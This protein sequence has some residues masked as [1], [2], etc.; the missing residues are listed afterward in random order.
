MFRGISLLL[1]ATFPSLNSSSVRA[2]LF[3]S[4]TAEELSADHCQVLSNLRCE[5]FQQL[6]GFLGYAFSMLWC[7]QV[8]NSE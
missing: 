2:S 7:L 4:D 3:V 1:N 6:S 5:D 8:E